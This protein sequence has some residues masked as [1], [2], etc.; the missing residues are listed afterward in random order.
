MLGLRWNSSG[1]EGG[2]ALSDATV[3]GEQYRN[4]GSG[5]T[6][7]FT[8]GERWVGWFWWGGFGGVWGFFVH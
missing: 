5:G 3:E 2:F 8:F 4:G 7:S 1:V 6:S